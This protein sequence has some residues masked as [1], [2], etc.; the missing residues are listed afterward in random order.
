MNLSAANQ[1]TQN[2]SNFSTAYLSSVAVT[3]KV[4]NYFADGSI[5]NYIKCMSNRTWSSIP[6]CERMEIFPFYLSFKKQNFFGGKGKNFSS[7]WTNFLTLDEAS[8]VPINK[9]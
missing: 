3:C 7:C 5:M 4:G 6:A 8:W 9:N 1:N 2:G